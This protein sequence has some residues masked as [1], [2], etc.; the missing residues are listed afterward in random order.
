VRITWLGQS[1]FVLGGTES[2]SPTV[3]LD[4]WLSP[5]TERATKPPTLAVIPRDIDAVIVSHGHGDH[6]DL[7]GLLSLSRSHNIR[8]IVV[9]SPHVSLVEREVPGA[10][11]VGVQ[12]GDALREPIRLWVTRAWH[13][14]TIADGYTDGLEHGPTPHVGY[15]LEVEG[16][17]VY[18]AGDTLAPAGAAEALAPHR[19]DVALLPVNGRDVERES[20]GIVGN[21][22]FAEAFAF[23]QAIGA[24]TMIPMHHDGVVGNTSD[25]TVGLLAKLSANEPNVLIPIRE[26]T[27][28]L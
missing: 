5:H 11:I 8:R 21:L 27:Y 22:D 28:Y 1:G 17:H 20:R 6:L 25:V 19:I 3:L 13:G 15:V 18:H 16:I 9:P 26:K 12:P 24:T 4:P 23:A 10:L 7:P 2:T 14:Q